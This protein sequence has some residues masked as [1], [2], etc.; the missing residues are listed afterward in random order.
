MRI[1]V[2]ADIH[3][4]IIALEAVLA[5][6]ARR[7]ADLLVNLGDCASGPLWPRETL[8]RLI[9]LDIPTVR[10]NHDRAIATLDRNR[11]GPSDGFGFDETDVAQQNW[12]GAL[13]VL[14]TISPGII[15]FHASPDDDNLY[16]LDTIEDGRLVRDRAERIAAR[17]W[18]LEA[19]LILCGHSHRP[20]LMRL[21]NGP[22]ILN[23]GSIG[24]PAYEDTTYV[25]ESGSPHARYAIVVAKADGGLGVEM[26]AVLY[27]HEIAARRAEAN[28]RPEWAHGLR[29][30]LMPP[31]R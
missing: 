13:P 24:C 23:P 28:G 21:P 25:S 17:L 6:L 9:A 5:D 8:A 15:A 30:G 4:N 2:L 31:L 12:L 18:R 29:H 7:G 10:G 3:G 16:L 22:L 26:F 1:A 20:D 11:M 27:D 14:Q 19:S